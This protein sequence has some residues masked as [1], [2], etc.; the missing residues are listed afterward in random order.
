[1]GCG[2]GSAHVPGQGRATAR[3]IGGEL[4]RSGLSNP[5]GVLVLNLAFTCPA[6]LLVGMVH[7]S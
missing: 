2:V 5:L 3:E 6:M 7:G 1:M 4:R